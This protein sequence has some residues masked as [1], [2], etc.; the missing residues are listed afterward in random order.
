MT[1]FVD[2]FLWH[3]GDLSVLQRIWLEFEEW[4]LIKPDFL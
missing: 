1:D 3:D 4:G 2:T